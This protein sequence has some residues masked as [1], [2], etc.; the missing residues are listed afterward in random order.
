[1][2]NA[3]LSARVHQQPPATRQSTH[4][5]ALV[6]I[7]RR[8][9]SRP[10]PRRRR[11][12]DSARPPVIGIDTPRPGSFGL[13]WVKTEGGRT[14]MQTRA[15][16]KERPRRNLLLM[17]DGSRSQEALL[18]S[19]TGISED[20]FQELRRLDLI[21]PAAGDVSVAPGQ[22]GGQDQKS[23]PKA[24]AR[25]APSPGDQGYGQFTAA[26][27]QLIS[28]HLGLRGFTLTLAV[29]KAQTTAELQAVAQRVI[30]MIRERKGD[31]TAAE[32]T[33]TLYGS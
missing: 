28:T 19:L 17:I 10:G 8:G 27:T 7:P 23:A 32:A 1:M 18:K 15:L 24:A 11:T 16:V 6:A 20:D 22:P 26:L 21:A 4:L 29:E 31:D 2:Q 25:T 5:H 33:K 12:D 14:E 30:E 13:I 3:G 9:A